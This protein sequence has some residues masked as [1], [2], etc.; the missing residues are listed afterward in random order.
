MC[1]PPSSCLR[2]CT[3]IVTLLLVS[4]VF[5]TAVGGASPALF[6]DDFDGTSIDTT[7]WIVQE[8]VNG[9]SGGSITV[10]DSYVSLT[11]DGTSFPCIYTATNPFPTSGD[12]AVEFDIK[13]T[14]V[15]G[16]G[17]GLWITQGVFEPTEDGVEANIMQVWADFDGGSGPDVRA[18][19]LGKQV[20]RRQI[21]KNS[22]DKYESNTFTF[23]LQCS[24]DVYTLYLNNELLLSAQSTLRADTI[25]F[26]HPP[27]YYVPWS[28]S[29]PWSSFEINSIRLLEPS[30]LSI[31]TNPSSTIDV[32]FKVDINGKLT[33][34]AGIALPSASVLLSYQIPS[35]ST[36]NPITSAI[37]D[38]N[39]DYAITWFAPATGNFII[40]TEWAGDSTYAGT[41]VYKNI[42]ITDSSGEA[43]FLAES[44]STLSSLAFNSTSKEIGFTAS[45]PSGTTGYVRFVILKKVMENLTDFKVFLDGKQIQFTAT[46]EGE[47]YV[48]YFQYSHS[49][50]N[51]LIKMLTSATT[52]P[53]E[54]QQQT[55]PFP[56]TL[57]I[58]SVVCVA[59]FSAVLLVYVKK[60]KH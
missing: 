31:S 45:G 34:R 51:I 35:T 13:Y 48:L 8:N 50:H 27:I 30:V 10:A 20:F 14:R 12:F 32:G 54:I 37:T 25:G 7:K 17:T 15:S 6:S 60:H 2:K 26:G 47:M 5:S 56:T 19:L 18:Y 23:R 59:A 49:S 16:W 44:N 1:F 21:Q 9:G 43:L 39:G 42:S 36:W 46:S 57:V 22:L 11:S 53:Q 33:D 24:G 28:F 52:A 4:L 41:F 55:E 3:L 38:A 40:K 29:Y 58:V